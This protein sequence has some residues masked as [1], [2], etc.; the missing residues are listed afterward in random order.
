MKKPEKI[1]GATVGT[2]DEIFKDGWNAC[3]EEML[4]RIEE[5]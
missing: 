1:E 2:K 4:R 3:R 5:V